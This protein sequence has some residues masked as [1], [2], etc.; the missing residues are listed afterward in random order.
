MNSE[1]VSNPASGEAAVT[2]TDNKVL[3]ALLERLYAALA[4]GPALNAQP[5]NSRQR[6]VIC[7]ERENRSARFLRSRF[8]RGLRR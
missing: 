7:W 1:K 2:P 6:C 4:R 3:D 8:R 5:G